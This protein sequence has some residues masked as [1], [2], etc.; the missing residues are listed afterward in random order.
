MP[1]HPDQ[2]T[3]RKNNQST[4]HHSN[5]RPDRSDGHAGQQRQHLP[6]SVRSSL[7]TTGPLGTGSLQFLRE[8]H[9]SQPGRFALRLNLLV[10][11]DGRWCGK[12]GR[13]EWCAQA[14]RVG[15]A[16]GQRAVVLSRGRRGGSSWRW[17][18]G[19]L[20]GGGRWRRVV[21]RGREGA[22]SRRRDGS[23]EERRSLGWG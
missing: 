7:E 6:S 12:H 19:G 3:K 5:T 23:R 13:R 20:E 2:P 10:R 16:L 9:L 14:G 21:E 1:L 15:H 17:A 11:L 22:R 18:E 8:L 4:P